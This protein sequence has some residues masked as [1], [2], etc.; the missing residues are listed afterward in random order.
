MRGLLL[1][2][3]IIVSLVP[4]WTYAHIIVSDN[5]N[6]SVNINSIFDIQ[7]NDKDVLFP[8]VTTE[9]MNVFK[10]EHNRIDDVMIVYYAITETCGLY[11]YRFF[12]N[13]WLPVIIAPKLTGF[14]GKD[15]IKGGVGML[16][17]ELV[18]T[19]EAVK[20]ILVC[21]TLHNVIDTGW[22][23]NLRNSIIAS[24]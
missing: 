23:F 3:V 11:I 19:N 24:F 4:L 17:C 14:I 15:Y 18:S 16:S 22:M 21:T 1:F 8:R 9:K 10:S 7:S 13:L 2:F 20:M 12:Q 6:L 5:Y